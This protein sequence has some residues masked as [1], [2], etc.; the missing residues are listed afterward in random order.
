M[1]PFES[2]AKR[3]L[4]F[5]NKEGY[6]RFGKNKL[7]APLMKWE[8]FKQEVESMRDHAKAFENAYNGIK[9]SIENQDGI[10]K[11][12]KAF[13]QA[14]RE[15]VDNERTRLRR[16]KGRALDRKRTYV[17]VCCLCLLP[18]FCMFVYPFDPINIALT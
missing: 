18:F 7:F 13:P 3:R 8:A 15:Q 5:L 4:A 16:T 17:S 6:D 10:E 1:L 11:V 9:R 12:L 14:A 2:V